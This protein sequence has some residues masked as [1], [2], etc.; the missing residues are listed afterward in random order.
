MDAT[1]KFLIVV[2]VVAVVGMAILVTVLQLQR[3]KRLCEKYLPD[4]VTKQHDW[5]CSVRFWFGRR[6][7]ILSTGVTE[8]DVAHALMEIARLYPGWV[9]QR[10]M[11]GEGLS[12]RWVLSLVRP[13]KSPV[14]LSQLDGATSLS[15]LAIGI[16]VDGQPVTIAAGVHTLVVA[17]TGWGKSNLMA[18]MI[19]QLVPFNQDGELEFWCIDLK[20]GVE[21]S[22]YGGGRLFSHV[23]MTPTEAVQLLKALLSEME[24]RATAIKGDFRDIRPSHRYPRIV[25]FIDE[26]A[27]LLNRNNGSEAEDSRRLLSSILGRSRSFGVVVIAFTQNPRVESIPVRAGFPQRVAMRLNDES[28]AEMLLGKTAIEHGA[29][30]WLI[31]LKGGGFV[32]DENAGDMRYF[33]A[34][35]IDD[36]T[37][38][39]MGA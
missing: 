7:W 18:T 17:L 37:V 22:M 19:A 15:R 38:K 20:F 23:A 5:K 24:R 32:W 14:E 6:V 31:N 16:G 39:T 4:P 8:H 11:T 12:A 34:P 30:P 29:V 1:T 9:P 3:L 25:L 21:A 2:V 26:T 33:R 13:S 35:L 36:E 28:E 10:R 27:E